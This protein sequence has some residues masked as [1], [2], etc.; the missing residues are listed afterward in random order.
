MTYKELKAHIEVMD[1]E[2]VEM[3]VVIFNTDDGEYIPITGIDFS[4]GSDVI[5]DNHPVLEFFPES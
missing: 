4:V 2:Q 5:D 3:D 1:K